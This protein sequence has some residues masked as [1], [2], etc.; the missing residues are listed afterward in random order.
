MLALSDLIAKKLEGKAPPAKK[1]KG[2]PSLG[3]VLADKRYGDGE[4]PRNRA[5]KFF[6]TI[7]SFGISRTADFRRIEGIPRRRWEDAEDLDELIVNLNDFL[8][9]PEGT[10]E[11]WPVQAAALRDLHDYRGLVGPIPVG[12][13]KALISLLAPVV[14]ESK[15]PLLLVPAKVREQT[16]RKV[17]PEMRKH[18]RLHPRLKIM[19]YSELSLEKNKNF[20]ETYQPDLIIADEAHSLAHKSAGRTKRVVRYMREFQNTIFVP[21]SGT[22]TRKGLRDYWHMVLWALKPILCPLPLRWNELQDWGD[23]IDADVPEEKRMAPGALKRFCLPGDNIRQGFMRRF[24]ETPGVVGVKTSNVKASLYLHEKKV[25]SSGVVHSSLFKMQTDWETPYGDMITEAVDLARKLTE[26]STGFF[27]R[28]DPEPPEEWLRARKEWKHYVRETLRYNKRKLDT[29][30]QVWNEQENADQPLGIW[31]EWKKIRKTFEINTVPVWVD[32]YMVKDAA[33]WLEKNDGIVWTSHV[34]F[35]K[36]LAEYSGKPYFG[37]G[38]QAS[39][40]ILDARGPIIASVNAHS[41]GKN[42]QHQWAKNLIICPAPSGQ[43]NEQLMGR[44][45]RRHQR[46]DEVTFEWYMHTDIFRS[47]WRTALIDARYLEDSTGV[48]QKL[49]YGTKTFEV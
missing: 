24:T 12:E 1:K 31:S 33:Q 18:W 34:A 26:L 13:G 8:R 30:L 14:L 38:K 23:A 17:I 39:I 29:E 27:Y 16:H 22:I 11:L 25:K 4:E 10:M 21:L 41:E 19:G 44:T 5:S 37:A 32:D 3:S 35:A 7:A 47:N 43:V 15:R 42:L 9:T 48:R 20:L 28:W 46:E 40:E 49:L 6:K 45:H 2:G 36:K